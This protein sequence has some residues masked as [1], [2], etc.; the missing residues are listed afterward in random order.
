[1]W[2]TRSPT[3]DQMLKFKKLALWGDVDEF[4]C[5][6]PL[7]VIE[8][9]DKDK[10]V[11]CEAICLWMH[12]FLQDFCETLFSTIDSYFHF[13]ANRLRILI[14]VFF[15]REPSFCLIEIFLTFPEIELEIF[16]N[17]S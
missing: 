1:M 16:L 14:H 2:E 8:I 5:S 17:F 7:V 11:S 9:Y 10:N 15:I 4:R 3:W 12:A 13:R 6:P